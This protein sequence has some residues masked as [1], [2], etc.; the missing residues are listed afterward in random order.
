MTFNGEVIMAASLKPAYGRDYKSSIK[1]KEDWY[2]GKD[3]IYLNI[4][5]RYNNKPCSCRDFFIGEMLELRYNNMKS[6][7]LVQGTKE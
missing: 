5:D 1:A 4:S 3:F 6:V 2:N 7:T